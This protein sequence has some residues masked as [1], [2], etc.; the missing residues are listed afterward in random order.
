MLAVVPCGQTACSVTGVP[1]LMLT[2]PATGAGLVNAI[3][4]VGRGT[5]WYLTW[6]LLVPSV[7]L[8]S[9]SASV[10][11]ASTDAEVAGFERVTVHVASAA[12][13][14]QV[15]RSL[16]LS[17]MLADCSSLLV[18]AL[19]VCTPAFTSVTALVATRLV[20]MGAALSMSSGA[21]LESELPEG[22][23]TV[24]TT[25]AVPEASVVRIFSDTVHES[26]LALTLVA[27]GRLWPA[28]SRSV[29][30]GLFEPRSTVEGRV[31]DT[32]TFWLA[33]TACAVP[34][35]AAPSAVGAVSL[36]GR[37]TR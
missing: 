27:N 36:K 37:R 20:T 7:V 15:P 33:A 28:P 2:L 30:T 10:S 35:R 32:V 23:V 6:S 34:S 13:T 21:L 24:A 4:P 25:S 19:I 9:L 1:G 26:P 14:V 17:W 3:V 5:S 16:L 29:K 18:T 12:D 31:S 11:V 8:P 22:S